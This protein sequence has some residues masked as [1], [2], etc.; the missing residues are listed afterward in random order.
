VLASDIRQRHVHVAGAN[1][2]DTED[3]CRGHRVHAIVLRLGTALF[4]TRVIHGLDA[5]A[6]L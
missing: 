5:L 6:A 4:E 1:A 3:V 2:D